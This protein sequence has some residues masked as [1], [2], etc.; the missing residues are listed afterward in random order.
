MVSD[1]EILSEKLYLT[2]VLILVVMEDGLR[3]LNLLASEEY[4]KMS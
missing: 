4:T 3:L 2:V 1:R